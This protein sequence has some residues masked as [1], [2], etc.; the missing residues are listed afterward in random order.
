LENPS[1]KDFRK[2]F[3]GSIRLL[4]IEDQKEL[5]SLLCDEIFTSPIISAKSVHSFNDAKSAILS[6]RRY[7]IW[8]LDLT[9]ERHNDGIELFY[10]KNN[11]P[12]SI[13]LTGCCS[14]TDTSQA[15]KAGAYVCYDKENLFTKMI[16]T[17]V[18]SVSNLS[19]LSFALRAS[20]PSGWNGFSLLLENFIQTPEEWAEHYFMTSRSIWNFCKMNSGITPNQFLY[21]FHALRFVLLSDCLVKNVPAYETLKETMAKSLDFYLECINFVLKNSEKVYAPVFL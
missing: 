20:R 3:A 10:M 17:F 1:I 13:V 9:L 7:H 19:A 21:L 18:N 5:C 12:Y 4:C 2:L 6:K 11:F 14:A 15:M 8:L 16:N